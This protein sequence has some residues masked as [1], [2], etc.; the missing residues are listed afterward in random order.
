MIPKTYIEL[1]FAI[2]AIVYGA[3]ALRTIFYIIGI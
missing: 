2:A 3:Q 1:V